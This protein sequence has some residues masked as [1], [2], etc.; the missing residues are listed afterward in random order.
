MIRSFLSKQPFCNWRGKMNNTLIYHFLNSNTTK[1]AANIISALA[2]MFALIYYINLNRIDSQPNQFFF[3]YFFGIAMLILSFHGTG[4]LSRKSW[5]KG[6]LLVKEGRVIKILNKKDL[7]WRW[8]YS[9][10]S[11][12]TTDNH[13]M[14]INISNIRCTIVF[15]AINNIVMAQ[16]YYD[17]FM[18][19]DARSQNIYLE[20]CLKNLIA[21]NEKMINNNFNEPI[22]KKQQALFFELVKRK[23]KKV[24]EYGL[25]VKS[26]TFDIA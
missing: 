12:L 19:A 14:Q 9:S 26:A 4:L 18:S 7:I 1:Y 5:P 15:G 2:L 20:N 24:V 13:L 16:K 22:N 11:E 25:E 8:D 23:T 6:N 10:L 3:F 21:E 17:L